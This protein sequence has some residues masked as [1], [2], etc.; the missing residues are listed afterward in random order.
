MLISAIAIRDY[1]NVMVKRG[2]MQDVVLADSDI[3][4]SK[5][6]DPYYLVNSSQYRTVATNIIKLTGDGGIGFDM[7]KL[8]DLHAFGAF[9][10]AASTSKTVRD[11]HNLWV[12]YGATLVGTM[13]RLEVR[14][15]NSHYVLL[16][17]VSPD[18]LDP[19]FQF[20]SEEILGLVYQWGDPLVGESA[21]VLEITL[22]YS[23]PEH[24]QRYSEMFSCPI[25]FAAEQTTVKVARD[26][27]D[28]RVPTRDVEFNAICLQYCE[29]IQNRIVNTKPIIFELR[30]IFSQYDK[31]PLPTFEEVARLLNLTPR[32]LRRRLH[33]EH[34]SYRAQVDEYRAEQAKK[35]LSYGSITPK[36]IAFLLGFND[37]SAF[38]N[39]FK[40]WTGLTVREFCTKKTCEPSPWRPTFE[41]M[42]MAPAMLESN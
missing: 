25:R 21:P 34:T 1:V 42:A 27:F 33:D 22:S 5:L 16:A 41:K 9:G 18:P 23:A 40:A 20:C 10:H 3:D 12:R 26:W 39:A 37:Q 11:V 7:A 32:T 36:E 30:S 29:N 38:R 31:Y 2:F 13:G 35:Y 8:H 15:E 6:D 28:S 4:F 14:S 17:I 24:K 19:L